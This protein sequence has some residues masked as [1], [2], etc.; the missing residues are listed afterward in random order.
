MILE[1]KNIR[2]DYE[3]LKWAVREINFSA[4]NGQTLVLC[5][6]PGSGK[7]TILR[8]IAGLE[9]PA[10][11]EILLDGKDYTNIY[12]KHKDAFYMQSTPALFERY[13]VS[14]NLALGLKYRKVEKNEI[15]ARVHAIAEQMGIDNLLTL[16]P[17]K[18]TSLEKI[19]IGIARIYIRKPKL[20][21]LDDPFLFLDEKDSVIALSLI[22]GLA[23]ELGCVIIYA[24]TDP[25]HAKEL[26]TQTAVIK[27]GFIQQFAHIDDITQNPA[28]KY[29]EV[30]V[31]GSY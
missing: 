20:I 17:K 13:T 14:K 11:G 23:E 18:L 9:S 30:F 10:S 26:Q 5:G 21:L 31:S 8:M 3:G 27:E 24:C 7:S 28:N 29:V 15:A 12:P 16:K 4:E 19:K 6:A 2:K 22:K 25:N 1:L